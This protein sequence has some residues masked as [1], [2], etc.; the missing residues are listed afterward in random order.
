MDFA[1]FRSWE[2]DLRQARLEIV[3]AAAERAN[4]VVAK[5]GAELLVTGSA[6]R[7]EVHPWSDLDL[8]VRLPESAERPNWLWSVEDAAGLGDAV[9][10]LTEDEIIPPLRPGLIGGARQLDKV[11]RQLVPLPDPAVAEDRVRTALGI[12]RPAIAQDRL[13]ALQ[14]A[15]TDNADSSRLSPWILLHSA[16]R[17]GYRA[18]VSLKR[19]AVYHDGGRSNW[20]DDAT[21]VASLRDLVDRLAM[22]DQGP[23]HRDPMMPAGI[24]ADIANLI[25]VA[26]SWENDE[27]L[28]SSAPR[29]LDAFEAWAEFVTHA[30]AGTAEMRP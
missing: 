26:A 22:P 24:G 16:R 13:A 8:I 17:A 15:D 6:A 20:L 5:H 23:Y 1:G 11:E 18:A 27:D 9:T 19:L 2:D 3:L 12:V 10:V 25:S 29:L 4:A 28:V 30:P 14:I 21:D 7:G